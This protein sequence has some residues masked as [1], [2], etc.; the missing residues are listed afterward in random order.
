MSNGHCLRRILSETTYSYLFV[1]FCT[2][3]KS[4]T[5][6]PM[7]Y[8]CPLPIPSHPTASDRSYYGAT[9]MTTGF[10]NQDD[11]SCVTQAWSN[12]GRRPWVIGDFAWTG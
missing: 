1:I 12:A 2:C 9:N 11:H 10:V 4:R 7:Q 5:P 3:H 6:K 8:P